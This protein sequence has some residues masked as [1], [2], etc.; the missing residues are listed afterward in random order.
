[1]YS[2]IIFA[3]NSYN[4]RLWEK[5]ELIIT[6]ELLLRIIKSMK[7]E[8][9]DVYKQIKNALSKKILDI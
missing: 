1:M 2:I 7:A 8:D 9:Y 5:I 6:Y 4:F 3:P